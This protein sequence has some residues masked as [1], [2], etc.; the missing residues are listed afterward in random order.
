MLRG[1]LDEV[2]FLRKGVARIKRRHAME[3][4]LGNPALSLH[5]VRLRTADCPQL[6]CGCIELSP[7]LQLEC[8]VGFGLAEYNVLKEFRR[9]VAEVAKVVERQDNR[10]IGIGFLETTR[11]YDRGFD[12][13]FRSTNGP[14]TV[15]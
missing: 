5:E 4:M 6:P 10:E 9:N 12:G 15:T 3:D 7:L 13:L 11:D 14:G 8:S 2:T 1:R